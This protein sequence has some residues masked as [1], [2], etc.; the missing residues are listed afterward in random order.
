VPRRPRDEAPWALH[1]VVAKGNGG[2]AIVR[3][4]IDRHS[5]VARLDQTVVRYRWHCLAYCL[6]DT[7]FHL[8]VRTPE[9]NLAEGMRRLKSVHAQDLNYRHGRT[10]HLFG[11][12]YYAA[13]LKTDDHLV[14]ALIYVSLNP[15]RAGVVRAPEEWPWSSYS[16]T[17]GSEQAPRFLDVASVLELIGVEPAASRRRLVAAVHET[18]ALDRKRWSWS[19]EQH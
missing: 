9:P 10:G 3:N 1:H 6:L 7:H 5:F 8:V 14:A 18:L 2:D 19:R 13:R 17:I 16:A 12:R 11:G 4:D 15:V